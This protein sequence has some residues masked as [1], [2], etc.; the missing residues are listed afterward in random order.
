MTAPYYQDDLVTLYH[1]DCREI[2][3]WLT[4]DVLVTDPPYGRNWRQGKIKG[5]SGSKASAGIANDKDTTAR[6]E[7]LELWGDRKGI[8]FGDLMLPP[9]SLTKLVCVYYKQGD[10]AIGMRGAMGGVRRDCEAIYLTGKWPSGLGGR[11]S[12]FAT[13]LQISSVNGIVRRNGGHPHTKPEDVMRDLLA[14]CDGAIADP[15][16]GSGSTLVAAKALG[17]HAIGVE[18]YEGYCRIAAARLGSTE[19]AIHHD[20]SLFGASAGSS[21]V[22]E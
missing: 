4:A 5:K 19:H 14:L 12:V 16:V 15:F 2:S 9:P 20:G 10:P 21:G 13:S 22:Q 3:E 8:V 18:L 11:S 17:R 6:D 1:G 7:A